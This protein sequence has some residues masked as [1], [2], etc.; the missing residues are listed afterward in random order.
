MPKGKQKTGFRRAYGG[1]IGAITFIVALGSIFRITEAIIGRQFETVFRLIADYIYLAIENSIGVA[2]GILYGLFSRYLFELPQV[3]NEALPY[4]VS[5]ASILL[6]ALSGRE[7]IIRTIYRTTV[8]YAFLLICGMIVFTVY[9]VREISLDSF[10]SDVPG[11]R[12]IEAVQFINT[13]ITQLTDEM[14][15]IL[16]VLPPIV[17]FFHILFAA[18]AEAIPEEGLRQNTTR[19]SVGDV[20]IKINAPVIITRLISIYMAA[21]AFIISN[22]AI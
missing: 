3:V 6:F 5:S 11:E 10:G 21:A 19:P 12:Y 1:A 15:S 18:F 9:I 20:L 4:V 7:N 22:A 14:F 13:S 2:T 17:V 16:I 8:L